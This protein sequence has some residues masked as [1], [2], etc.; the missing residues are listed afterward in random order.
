MKI[1]ISPP[2][3][4]SLQKSG[5]LFDELFA[6]SL[7]LGPGQ[8]IQATTPRGEYLHWDKLRHLQTPYGL[9][10]AQWW[11]SV[12]LARKALYKSLPFV[13]KYNRPFLLATPDPV[14]TKLH[15]ID[16]STGCVQSPT[17]VLNKTMRDSYLT[18]SLIEEAITSSQLEG[19]S[20]TRKNAKEMLRTRRKPRNKSEKMIVNNFH[21]MEFVRSVKKESL[22]PEIIFELHRILTLDTLDNAS[23]AGHLRTS[24]DIHVWDNTD[25]ILHTPPDFIELR[26]RLNR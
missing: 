15:S 8:S 7:A 13:D 1:P 21:A 16:R 2:D 12:K 25:Q 18:R 14:L 23:D 3:F 19:A 5:H 24:N 22:T 26:A 6:H 20:T 17:I 4:E 9:S 10:S 11:F